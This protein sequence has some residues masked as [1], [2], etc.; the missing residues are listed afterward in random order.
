MG[1][2]AQSRLA[3]G[4]QRVAAAVAPPPL[5]LMYHRIA[6]D[7][8]DPW[9]LCV[10]PVR[11]AAQMEWIGRHRR[12]MRLRELVD[13][14]AQGRCPRKAVVVSFD[15]G[16]RDNLQAALPVLERCEVPA[17]VFCTAGAI[18]DEQGFWWD[19]LAALLLRPERLPNA[20]L[21]DLGGPPQRIELGPAVDHDRAQR[22]ADR[23]R[24]SDDAMTSP[25]LAFYREV[26]ALLRPL[27]D[28]QREASIEGIARWC[29]AER[30]AVPD[31]PATLTPDETRALAASAWIEIGAH[32]VTHAALSTLDADA[33]R[34]EIMQSKAQLEALTG[35]A[36]TSFAYPFGNQG[37]ET[38]AL[39]RE[40]GFRAA[41]TTE[42]A[43]VHAAADPFQLP[44]LAVGDWDEATFARLWHR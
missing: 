21:L 36:V 1:R 28:T 24:G 13:A 37:A 29:A 4:W 12:P 25:R 30:S 33:Q 6:D 23:Q 15:D 19:R 38:A 16:Y 40:A 27:T 3:R 26:W 41:C 44:R 42:A 14:L 35:R 7:A 31:A 18:G 34:A 43:A 22:A 11:F 10:S 20:L 9:R 2:F 32:S 39:V 5:I 8:I 17:T